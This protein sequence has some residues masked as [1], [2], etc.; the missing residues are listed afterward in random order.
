[1]QDAESQNPL[2]NEPIDERRAREVTKLVRKLRW[3][4]EDDQAKELERKL[5]SAGCE[6]VFTP[7]SDTD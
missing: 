5:L 1:M 7:P 2:T 3:I 6:C 4:G